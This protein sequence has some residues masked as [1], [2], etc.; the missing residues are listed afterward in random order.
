M[1]HD[2]LLALPR[3]GASHDTCPLCAPGTT[4][5][6]EGASVST[7]TTVPA[8]VYSEAQHFALLESAVARESASLTEAKETLETAVGTLEGE[9]AK[10]ADELSTLKSRLDVL[11]AEKAAAEARADAA[12]QELVAFK[13]DLALQ[14]EIVEKR[15]VRVE[16]IKAATVSLGDDYFTPERADRWAQ[17]SDEAFEALVADLTEAAAAKPA[18]LTSVTSA[19]ELARESAAFAGGQTATG[20]GGQS[21]LS[22][23]LGAARHTS[24][25][26][27]A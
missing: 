4:S 10:Q 16:R 9:K 24:T 12:G 25:T 17:L 5:A 21:T 27:P 14:G 3:N 7:T 23:L 2:A 20:V 15:G 13:A 18:D 22:R 8:N 11:E 19:T 26:N 1:A 6:K